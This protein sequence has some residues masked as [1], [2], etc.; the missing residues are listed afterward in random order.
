[1]AVAT[2]TV[3]LPPANACAIASTSELR[4][5]RR[6]PTKASATGSATADIYVLRNRM[7]VEQFC[8]LAGR[9]RINQY[10]A[11]R[12]EVHG[13]RMANHRRT[14]LLRPPRAALA[15]FRLHLVDQ[16]MKYCHAAS[17]PVT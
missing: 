14:R 17:H 5:A 16:K 15:R 4:R 8:F 9:L 2:S 6:S 12:S 10:P 13:A 11:R 7:S 3:L 1:A